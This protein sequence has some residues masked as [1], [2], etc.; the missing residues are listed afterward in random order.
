MTTG[1]PIADFCGQ[2]SARLEA[3]AREY[4][5]RSFRRPPGH[6]IREILEEALDEAGWLFVLWCQAQWKWREPFFAMAEERKEF[7]RTMR[8]RIRNE[9]RSAPP[10]V[11]HSIP[12]Q[13]A[14]IEA[15]LVDVFLHHESIRRRLSGVGRVLE[16]APDFEHTGRR[17]SKA[18]MRSSD[19]PT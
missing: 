10:A 15:L 18:D 8:T 3:G 19:G 7:L 2:V 13:V 16:L 4:G 1:D 6:I 5:D 9:D 17:G 12:T 11:P 14:T